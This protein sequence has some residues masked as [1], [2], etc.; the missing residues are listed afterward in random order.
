MLI[1]NNFYICTERQKVSMLESAIKHVSNVE[2]ETK[3]RFLFSL[4]LIY[5][6][7]NQQKYTLRITVF[8][9]IR[10]ECQTWRLWKSNSYYL[11]FY[12]D[13]K[14]PVLEI[15]CWD[16]FADIAFCMSWIWVLLL[17]SRCS[18][19]LLILFLS[20]R[21]NYFVLYTQNLSINCSNFAKF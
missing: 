21:L 14:T 13:N 7:W 17:L 12:Q 10:L 9:T 1:E 20:F 5:Y 11:C 18:H 19:W 8:T 16:T 6:Y 4:D 3:V 15:I 2:C